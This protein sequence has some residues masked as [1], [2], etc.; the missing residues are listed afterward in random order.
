[1]TVRSYI[2]TRQHMSRKGVPKVCYNCKIMIVLGDNVVSKTGAKSKQKLY[3]QKCAEKIY[4]VEGK[5]D[6]DSYL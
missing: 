6:N 4:L 2:F 1:M 5:K 3:H